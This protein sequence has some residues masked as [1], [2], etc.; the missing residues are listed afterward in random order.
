MDLVQCPRCK[1]ERIQ[2]DYDDAVV[3]LRMVGLHKLLC[4]NCGLVF[5]GFDPLGS[6]QRAPT[7]QKKERRNRRRG[8]RFYAHL[9]SAISFIDGNAKVGK[10]SYSQPSRGHC[11]TIGKFGMKFSLAGTRFSETD[12]STMGRLLF[13][14]VDLPDGPIEAVVKIVSSERMGEDAKKKWL[15]GVTI[16]QMTEADTERLNDYLEKRLK[17]DP[18]IVSD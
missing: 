5:K 4:N 12:L 11:E 6:R 10:V 18:V 14:R 13:V 15:L 1:S 3:F 17:D 16:H 2:R 9:P 7:S 8:P